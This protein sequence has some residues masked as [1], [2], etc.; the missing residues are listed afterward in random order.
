ML[1]NHYFRLYRVVMFRV[2]VV[3]CA[4]KV[5]KIV[6]SCK[7]TREKVTGHIVT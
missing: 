4:T 2:V 5:V 1:D 6:E 3:L 7:E